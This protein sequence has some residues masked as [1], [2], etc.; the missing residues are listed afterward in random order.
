MVRMYLIRKEWKKNRKIGKKK[1]FTEAEFW[2]TLTSKVYNPNAPWKKGDYLYACSGAV[3]SGDWK[4][5]FRDGTGTM[6]W[7]DGAVYTGHWKDNHAC[8]KGKFEHV[9]GDVYEG[10]WKRDCAHGD[11]KYK[12]VEGCIY[13]GQW[14][15]D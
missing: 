6:K 4:G 15:E 1:Y 3:Y 2:E 14:V 11:G 13:K 10:S 5:G 12:S 7:A 8:G 9:S